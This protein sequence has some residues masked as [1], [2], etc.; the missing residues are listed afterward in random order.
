[1]YIC[2]VI[3]T[4][5]TEPLIARHLIYGVLVSIDSDEQEHLFHQEH[6]SV[7]AQECLL[8][9]FEQTPLC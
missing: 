7:P 8:Q 1:M 2:S 3:R 4:S 6:S 5:E 9:S